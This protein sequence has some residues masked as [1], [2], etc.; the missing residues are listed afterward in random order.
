MAHLIDKDHILAKI[1][2]LVNTYKE[3]PTRNSYEEG[4]RYGNRD[5]KGRAGVCTIC[6][7]DVCDVG[8]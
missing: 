8:L 7:H 3:C 2:N 4:L 1:E 5:F 6:K